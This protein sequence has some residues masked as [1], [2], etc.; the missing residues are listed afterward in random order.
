[1]KVDVNSEEHY[2]VAEMESYQTPSLRR[3]NSVEK[4]SNS[5]SSSLQAT[6]GKIMES[7]G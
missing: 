7:V 5:I 2:L 1:M 3:Q 4:L 6:G